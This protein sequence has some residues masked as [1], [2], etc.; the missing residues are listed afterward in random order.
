MQF[1]ST[2]STDANLKKLNLGAGDTQL[3]GYEPRDAKLGD[4]LFPLP[5]R[6]GSADE[7]RASH[8]F[9]HFSHRQALDVLKDWVRVLKPGGV[10]KLA[11]PDFEYIARGFLEGRP[12]P[13]QA[14]VCGAHT[15]ARD[16][17]LAQYDEPSLGALMREAGLVG[18]HRW[19]ADAED[20]S[21]LPVSL[22]LAA[23]K[24][25]AAWPKTIAV[26]SVP[27]LG[28][29]DNFFSAVEVVKRLGIPIHKT[30]GAFWGQCMQRSIETALA[31][32]AEWVLTLDY[33]TVFEADVVRDLLATAVNCA[34]VDAL[35]P[36]QMSRMSGVPLMTVRGEDGEPRRGI[37]REEMQA[38]LLPILT[39]HFGCTLLRAEALRALAKPWFLGVPE[40]DG[41]WGDGRTDDDTW[42][43]RQWARAGRRAFCAPRCVV[44]HFE[45][46]IIW[47]NRNLE[48][49]LQH[50]SEFW[51][52]GPPSGVWR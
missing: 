23:W 50:S 30:Q 14:Y 32:G 24:P 29:M 52:Q 34:G 46:F 15:D 19:A 21:S 48:N 13:W 45:G 27:R 35:M 41:T 9:E 37:D 4:S 22:N 31:E 47:P 8:V 49:E 17:H 42:F 18:V 28:F 44:G 26:M 6:T 1:R 38:T 3:A 36:L 33:D 5:D 7:I 39:G 16:V 10:L 11:T 12:E 51:R 40:K 20:C 25:P 2:A 43:W